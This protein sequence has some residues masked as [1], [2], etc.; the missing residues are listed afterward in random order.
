MDVSGAA[1]LS[2]RPRFAEALLDGSKT[3]EVR[4]RAAR[5]FPGALCL[6]YASSPACALLGALRVASVDVDDPETLWRRHGDQTALERPEFDAYLSGSPVA[7][8]I[9]V[10]EAVT[11]AQ[12]VPLSELRRRHSSFV[13]PQSYRFLASDEMAALLNGQAGDLA[14]LIE[15]PSLC[16]P[17][18]SSLVSAPMR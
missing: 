7:C 11:F 9:A 13:T 1:L 16:A 14:S 8:A 5:L 6:V 4:R 15:T 17:I 10:A 3:V 12:P 2:V 18:V